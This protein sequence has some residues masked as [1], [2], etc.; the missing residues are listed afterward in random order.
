M[1]IGLGCLAAVGLAVA[2]PADA[3][4]N[5]AESKHFVIYADERPKELAD[6]AA[7]LERFDKA[8][9]HARG[10][11]DPPI[12]D[13]NRL[14]VFVLPTVAAV[15]RLMGDKSNFVA[16]YYVGRASGSVAFVPRRA[17]T[18]LDGDMNADIVFFH[19]YAHHLMMQALDRPLPEWVVEGFA[20]F[21]STV[22]FESDGS[23]GLGAPANHRAWALFEGKSLP[24]ET[25]LSGNYDKITNE[26]RETSIYGQG[27]LLIH[28][29]TFEP[30]RQGQLDRYADLINRGTTPLDA[31]RSAFGDLK[32]LERDL[33]NYLNRSHMRYLKISSSVTQPG[34]VN[35]Q[36]LSEGAARI[37]LL[38][39]K[40]ESGVDAQTAEPLAAQMRAVE[41]RYPGDELV[42]ISLSEAEL[43]AKHPE[44]AEGAANRAIKV[45]AKSTDALVLKGRAIVERGVKM[46]ADAAEPLFDEARRLFIAANKI[47]AEDPEPLMEYYKA[48]VRE[49]RAPTA[50]AIAALHYASDLAPQDGSLRMNSAMQ[51]LDDGKLAEARRTLAPIA[52]DPHGRA[53]AK[54]AR[55]MMQRIDSGD[56]KGA[57]AA[58]ASGGDSKD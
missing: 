53:V 38:R 14:S 49:G 40:S 44:A 22:R 9:R 28:Y 26:E 37:I 56:G 35:V 23:V 46:D 43:D 29:L 16:G 15:Q 8:V 1:R 32:Q 42:E 51:Y 30:S 27:W 50:N 5:V 20:E 55:L 58:A 34:P 41:A 52:Y 18:G 12:G 21:M 7:R 25:L 57:I 54:I 3:A 6:F 17:G 11:D 4:W 33:R 19:E 31:A 2:T 39:A 10:M 48:F 47:D 13:G 36:P 45:D 24:L